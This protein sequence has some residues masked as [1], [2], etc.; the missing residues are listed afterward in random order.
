[1]CKKV[2]DMMCGN[3]TPIT[4]GITQTNV[5]LW[6]NPPIALETESFELVKVSAMDKIIVAPAQEATLVAPVVPKIIIITSN[7]L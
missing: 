4:T 5:S 1:M 6:A 7:L 2:M 3:P